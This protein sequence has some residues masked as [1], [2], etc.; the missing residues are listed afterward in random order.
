MYPQPPAWRHIGVVKD[1]VGTAGA[2]THNASPRLAGTRRQRTGSG[3][4]DYVVAEPGTG[5]VAALAEWV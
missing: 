2:P 4:A 5:A 1:G 3:R